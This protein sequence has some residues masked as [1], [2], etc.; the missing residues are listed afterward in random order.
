MRIS[1]EPILDFL[2]N[3]NSSLLYY[4]IHENYGSKRKP[5]NY[6]SPSA[7]KYSQA[8][9]KMSTNWNKYCRNLQ[10]ARS[11]GASQ[12]P[13]N[14]GLVSFIV[15]DIRVNPELDKLGIEH[16]PLINN[17]AHSNIIGLPKYEELSQDAYLEVQIILSR[18]AQ[19]EIPFE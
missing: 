8:D 13:E 14:Y 15:R 16:D 9:G 3:G 11:L 2:P 7:F 17:P 4:R 12:P 6:K 19:W 10:E 5:P 18:I 1:K